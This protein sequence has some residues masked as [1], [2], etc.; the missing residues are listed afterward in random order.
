MYAERLS[1][2][3]MLSVENE[4]AKKLDID[5]INFNLAV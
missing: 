3:A 5:L 2:L 4:R 1:D